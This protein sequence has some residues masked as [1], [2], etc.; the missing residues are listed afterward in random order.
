VTTILG[1]DLSVR[2]AAAVAVPFTWCGDWRG[3]ETFKCGAALAKTATDDE[4]AARLAKTARQLVR[5]ATVNNVTEAWLE[6]YAF[7]RNGAHTAGE[8]GGVV[9]VALADARIRLHTSQ[10]STARKLVLGHVPTG[11]DAI[12][13][14]VKS[15]WAAAGFTAGANDDDLADAMTAA[16]MGLVEAGAFCF[17]QEAA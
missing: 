8:V 13:A 3:V 10:M 2:C 15:T 9:R 6:S 12:K 7:S 1:L 5:F 16:N 14:A 11:R 17:C 4:R